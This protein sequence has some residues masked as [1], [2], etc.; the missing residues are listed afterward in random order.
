MFYSVSNFETIIAEF[1]NRVSSQ[2]S[3]TNEYPL[4]GNLASKN[5]RY[6]KELYL[7]AGGE[8]VVYDS[9][10][11]REVALARPILQR[12]HAKEQFQQAQKLQQRKFTY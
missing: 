7:A 5:E 4:Y 10:S 2:S 12:P 6:K 8:K 1:S 3:K 9:Y 11:C